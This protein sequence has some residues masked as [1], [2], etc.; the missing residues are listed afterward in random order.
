MRPLNPV[1]GKSSELVDIE[2]P[3]FS[4]VLEPLLAISNVML[5]SPNIQSFAIPLIVFVFLLG[6]FLTFW[7]GDG[8]HK[9]GGCWRGIAYVKCFLMGAFIA[10]GVFFA[11]TA[12]I[13]YARLIPWRFT[14]RSDDVVIADFQTH[15]TYSHDGIIKPVDNLIHHANMGFKVVCVTEHDN[16]KALEVVK[17][18]KSN[19]SLPAVIPGLERCVSISD[20]ISK[21]DNAFYVTVIGIKPG[22]ITEDE[23]LPIRLK[24][25]VLWAHERQE[26]AVIGM[27]KDMREQ[28]ISGYAKTGIDGFEL[29]SD[30]YKSIERTKLKGV[31]EAAEANDLSLISSS[32]WHG[33]TGTICSG[34]AV[35]IPGVK[36]MTPEQVATSVVKKL[37]ANK[38]EDFEPFV[39][40]D[41][42]KPGKARIIFSPLIECVQY[43]AGMP[44]IKVLAWWVWF[45]LFI[46]VCP[47]LSKRKVLISRNLIGGLMLIF[48]VTVFYRGAFLWDPMNLSYP[49]YNHFAGN[50]IFIGLL[51]LTIGL[52]TVDGLKLNFFRQDNRIEILYT[53]ED[54]KDPKDREGK[55]RGKDTLF[56]L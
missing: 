14:P 2:Y 22:T 25:I 39:I 20:D 44:F 19:V 35:R 5:T 29:V 13:V 43:F 27:P 7:L 47:I 41:Y 34:T 45:F 18:A 46:W 32:D 54:P 8:C 16:F 24:D 10:V 12:F 40:G 52:Y 23:V 17:L 3:F 55:E 38:R 33:W 4:V 15:T 9:E 37:R 1:T 51:L 36:T 26:A 28:L 56:P 48:G 6:G 31:I 49:Y 53:T 11:Y 30:A 42:V 50:G 21:M